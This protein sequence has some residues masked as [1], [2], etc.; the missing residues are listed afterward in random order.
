MIQPRGEQFYPT[1]H[2]G[3][4][5]ARAGYQLGVGLVGSLD[6]DQY[7]LGGPSAEVYAEGRYPFDFR[8]R[9]HER[10]GTLQYRG[11]IITG[12]LELRVALTG[13]PQARIDGRRGTAGLDRGGHY[14][15]IGCCVA[16]QA[17]QLDIRVIGR[18]RFVDVLYVPA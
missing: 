4:A 14:E 7:G 17:E 9:E 15:Q 1:A 12:I 6:Q 8:G 3:I 16:D 10:A 2:Q 11:T 18:N 13:G 5:N